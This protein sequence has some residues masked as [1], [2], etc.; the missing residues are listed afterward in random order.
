L[1]GAARIME[2][3]D[4][5]KGGEGGEG[6]IEDSAEIEIALRLVWAR[7]IDRLPE[8][9]TLGPTPGDKGPLPGWSRMPARDPKC[10]SDSHF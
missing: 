8:S 4:G 1:G 2:E 5:E 3:D 6:G 7:L 10:D 9:R